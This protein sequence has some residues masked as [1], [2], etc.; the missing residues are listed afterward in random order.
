MD[1][2]RERRISRK[3]LSMRGERAKRRERRVADELPTDAPAIPEPAIGAAPPRSANRRRASAPVEKTSAAAT[4]TPPPGATDDAG[5][6]NTL[7]VAT[8]VVR[9]DPGLY[10]VEITAEPTAEDGGTPR[11]PLV[12]LAQA[13]SGPGPRLDLLT[14]GGSGD[15]WLDDTDKIVAVRSPA[16]GSILMATAFGSPDRPPVSPSIIVRPLAEAAPQIQ[17]RAAPPAM[18]QAR[19]ATPAPMPVIRA[20]AEIRIEVTAHIER[21]GDRAFPGSTWVGTPGAQQRVEGFSIRPL[22]ELQ[23]S[24]IEYKALHPGGVETEWLPGPQFCG[25]RGQSLPITGFAIRIAP[26]VQDQFSVIYQAAFFR[27]GITEPRRNGAPCLPRLHGD[28]LEAINI[29]IVQARLG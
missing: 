28:A 1:S 6:T 26:H 23:P 10:A 24:E 12:W 14:V 9:L 22:Q 11:P 25:T 13:P 16:S 29:R 18:A 27:S 19:P 8:S 7:P 17:V 3:R 4:D 20:P 15:Q 21:V 5:L 2:G